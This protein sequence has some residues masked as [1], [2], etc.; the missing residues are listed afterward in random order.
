MQFDER[1]RLLDESSA[2]FRF[3][4]PQKP[5][6]SV[7]IY[8]HEQYSPSNVLLGTSDGRLLCIDVRNQS[9]VSETKAMD[10]LSTTSD[11]FV[12][13]IGA[14]SFNERSQAFVVTGERRCGKCFDVFASDMPAC[15]MKFLPHSAPS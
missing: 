10:S 15:D 1:M 9:A 11:P 6:S 14:I 5:N 4:L 2:A 12:P 7:A 13:C 3:D 8:A